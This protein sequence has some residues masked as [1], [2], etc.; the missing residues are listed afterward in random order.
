MR[1]P[2]INFARL[3]AGEGLPHTKVTTG[4]KGFRI[5]VVLLCGRGVRRFSHASA[6]FLLARRAA[7]TRSWISSG[8]SAMG[9]GKARSRRR[10]AC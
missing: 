7:K 6:A 4:L 10:D 2:A 5:F 9:L 1:A 3:V 8:A